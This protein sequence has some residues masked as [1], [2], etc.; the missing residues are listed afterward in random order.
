MA[1]NPNQPVGPRRI[2]YSNPALRSQFL[3]MI[4]ASHVGCSIAYR[5]EEPALNPNL[6]E[7]VRGLVGVQAWTNRARHIWKYIPADVRA[8][9]KLRISVMADGVLVLIVEH[10]Q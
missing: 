9:K 6:Q 10:E 8:N 2:A 5:W 4:S 7:Q 1:I 3:R